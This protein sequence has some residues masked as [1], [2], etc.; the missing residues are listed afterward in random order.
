[1]MKRVQINSQGVPLGP[2]GYIICGHCGQEAQDVSREVCHAYAC[3]VKCNPSLFGY[4][5]PQV[6][7]QAFLQSK[8]GV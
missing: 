4:A 1:M 7:F 6:R 8:G 3:H 5:D 2:N